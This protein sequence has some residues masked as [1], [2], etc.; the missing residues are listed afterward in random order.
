MS[1]SLSAPPLT[2]IVVPTYNE[3]E[4]VELLLP[5]LKAAMD[6]AGYPLEVIVADD[7]SPDGTADAADRVLREIGGQGRALRRTA[8]RGLSPAVIDGFRAATGALLGVI[9]ADLSHPPEKVPE[10]VRACLEGADLAIGSRY[11]AGGGVKEWPWKR[12]LASRLGCWLAFPVTRVK[13]ATSGF[14]L[15]RREVIDG[16]ALNA[17]G[18]KIG[19]EIF[20]KGR[21]RTR[22]EVPFVFAD[23]EHGQSKLGGK[24]MLQYGLH[25]LR[26]FVWRLARF[27]WRPARRV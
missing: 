26:L 24:V 8:N 15:C 6:A 22:R 25:V 12:R 23:R 3:R 4:N 17:S 5:R 1:V 9:D 13:D 7:S 2:S 11:V 27:A 20:V 14:F 19:L 21:Y 16:V 10:L 18:F